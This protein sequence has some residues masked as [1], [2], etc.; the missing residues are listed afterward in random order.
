ML[1]A[2]TSLALNPTNTRCPYRTKSSGLAQLW[3]STFFFRGWNS[4]NCFFLK[5]QPTLPVRDVTQIP[6]TH[7]LTSIHTHICTYIQRQTH[8]F[9]LTHIHRHT[10]ILLTTHIHWHTCKHSHTH[11]H[12]NTQ[13]HI[14][15]HIQIHTHTYIHTETDMK[16]T[17]FSTNSSDCT[18]HLS[19]VS[20]WCNG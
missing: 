20:S 14:H 13:I 5:S 7:T 8:T 2:F 18:K 15:K 17:C 19:G 4:T 16:C 1:T 3:K 11:I 12:S 6:C 9:T 10:D